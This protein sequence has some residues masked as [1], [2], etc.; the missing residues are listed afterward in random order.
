MSE[1]KT[2][3]RRSDPDRHESAAQARMA[4][5]V[6]AALAAWPEAERSPVE[7]DDFAE[8][9]V[10]TIE[11]GAPRDPRDGRLEDDALFGAP[12]PAEPGEPRQFSTRARELD[13]KTLQDI[14][15]LA[16]SPA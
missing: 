2:P 14:A 15:K 7:W 16:S 1:G 13:R 3:P 6:D 12:L 11:A 10:E 5:H 4:D 9:I 8:R